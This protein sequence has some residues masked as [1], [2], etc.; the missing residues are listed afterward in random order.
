MIYKG[1]LSCQECPLPLDPKCVIHVTALELSFG[2]DLT[3]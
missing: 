1:V 3:R 2:E